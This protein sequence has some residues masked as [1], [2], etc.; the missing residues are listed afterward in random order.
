MPSQMQ[1]V[2]A[3]ISEES[4]SMLDA[5]KL[6]A[7]SYRYVVVEN[8]E[9]AFLDLDGKCWPSTLV[10]LHWIYSSITELITLVNILSQYPYLSSSLDRDSLQE[11]DCIHIPIFISMAWQCLEHGR[12]INISWFKLMNGWLEISLSRHMCAHIHTGV[13]LYF[14]FIY[15]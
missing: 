1:A 4:P 6:L 9:S 13:S 14:D 7:F 2:L 10:L 11:R 12:L 5:N 3:W 8:A 15:S